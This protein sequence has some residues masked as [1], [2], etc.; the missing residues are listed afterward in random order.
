MPV[1][2]ID[3]PRTTIAPLRLSDVQAF[4]NP[5]T[6]RQDYALTSGQA[7]WLL[8]KW[9][10]VG[11]GRMF[12]VESVEQPNWTWL[13]STVDHAEPLRWEA[14][15]P[16]ASVPPER[17]SLAAFPL[18]S[19]FRLLRSAEGALNALHEFVNRPGPVNGGDLVEV[20]CELLEATGRHIDS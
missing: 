7:V 4:P 20:V 9:Q 11:Q 12:T 5:A 10:T 18:R 16:T 8:N 13:L 2:T 17:W 3:F 1:I 19:D 14:L 6:G 15:S